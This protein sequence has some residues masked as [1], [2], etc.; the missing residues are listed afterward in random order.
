A[1]LVVA[2]AELAERT[3]SE[4]ADAAALDAGTFELHLERTNLVPLLTQLVGDARRRAPG[5]QLKLGSPQGLTATIDV[6]RIQQVIG[7]AI[8]SAVRRNPRGC[9]IDIDLRRPL[10]GLAR[11][12][13]RDY[14]RPLSG[15]ERAA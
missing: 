12:E 13:I 1:R 15:R 3:L 4:L 6:S 2:R 8:E 14:G 5:H 11:I 10:G 7:A 9:W